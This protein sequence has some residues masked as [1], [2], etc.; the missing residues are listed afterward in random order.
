MSLDAYYYT[1]K[2]KEV[3]RS[4][5]RIKDVSLEFSKI[6]DNA[7][8]IKYLEKLL[9]ETKIIADKG[10][11]KMEKSNKISEIYRDKGNKAYSKK[12]F[13]DSLIQYNQSLCFADSN[14]NL[15][16]AYAN[17]SAVYFELGLYET[18][19]KN[20]ELAK[21]HDYPKDKMKKLEN[22]EIICSEKI[23]EKG[24]MNDQSM[25]NPL[26]EEFLKLSYKPHTQVPYIA[27]CLDLKQDEL[28][29]RYIIANRNLS[30]GDVV[31]IEEPFSK[32]LQADHKYEHCLNCLK[33]NFMSL[34]PCPRS[35][36]AMF[37]STECMNEALESF[38]KYEV[39]IIDK[40]N[41]LCT[42]ILRIGKF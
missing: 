14:E 30:P 17:R 3:L 13:I 40:L 6:V 7:E 32:S 39:D 25:S 15:S 35:T 9:N 10:K 1:D 34:T 33:D 36:S 31:I 16:L 22:R 21:K 2:L 19:L 24:F 28:F 18:C 11:L 26:G 23:A 8:R 4:D 37:C 42:K 20:I 29:G 38:Y 12:E 5:G 27:E 41:T